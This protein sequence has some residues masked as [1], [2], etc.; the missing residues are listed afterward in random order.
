MLL[1]SLKNYLF[2]LFPIKHHCENIMLKKY[3]DINAKNV[4]KQNSWTKLHSQPHQKSSSSISIDSH[5]Q[6]EKAANNLPLN[7]SKETFLTID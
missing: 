2:I 7:Q 4:Q 3:K 5:S 1:I 6:M